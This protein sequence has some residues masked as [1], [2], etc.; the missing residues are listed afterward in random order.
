MTPLP[1]IGM[2]YGMLKQDEMQREILNI[3]KLRTR[4]YAL[5][6]SRHKA[7][8]AQGGIKD[9][10]RISADRLYN[11]QIRIQKPKNKHPQRRRPKEGFKPGK[12]GM[13]RWSIGERR[14]AAQLENSYSRNEGALTLS[15]SQMEQLLK[16]FTVC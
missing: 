4:S 14:I 13:Y 5:L 6:G 10:R 9:T 1:N 16:L 11:I 2:A 12:T 15:W 7:R 8:C 3:D